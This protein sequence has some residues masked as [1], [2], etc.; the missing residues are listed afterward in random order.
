MDD[1]KQAQPGNNSL[2]PPSAPGN[3]SDKLIAVFEPGGG[4]P[5]DRRV[6]HV[7]DRRRR[8]QPAGTSYSAAT[9]QMTWCKPGAKGKAETKYADQRTCRTPGRC[10]S[11]LR[12]I[13]LLH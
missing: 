3:L 10:Y 13:Q 6:P 4:L 5:S 1:G 7:N 2:T 12:A 9:L 8:K 11:P